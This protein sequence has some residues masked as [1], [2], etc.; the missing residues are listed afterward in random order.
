[1]Q[2]EDRSPSNEN[3]Q[4]IQTG[5][6]FYSPL[7]RNIAQ[8]EGISQRELDNILGTGGEGR[9]TKQDVLNY[10][11]TNRT[12][13]SSRSEGPT[14]IDSLHPT[15]DN[16]PIQNSSVHVVKSVND[17][18]EIIEMDRMRRLIADHMVNS[19][20]TSP[21]VFSVVEA[22]VT[23]LVNWRNKVKDAYKKTE[24]ENITF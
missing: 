22:D 16:D 10:L 23:N 21:H 7:V 13:E 11:E 18:S 4:Q 17:D 20:K 12:T 2:V 19:V 5:I 6:R 9:V 3:A 24:G 1:D 14:G 15:T 8:Q